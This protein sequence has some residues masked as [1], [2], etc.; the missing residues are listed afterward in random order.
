M[1]SLFKHAFH[2]TNAS[3][4][5]ML[6]IFMLGV[7]S[8]SS[9]LSFLGWPL[10]LICI[11][12][13]VLFY[14]GML[15]SLVEVISSQELVLTF[16]N[17]KKNIGHF[18]KF[19]FFLSLLPLFVHL[20]LTEW[21]SRQ[22][23]P[24]P[25]TFFILNFLVLYLFAGIVIRQKYLKPLRL[26]RR[27]IACT[28]KDFFA[29]AA[30]LF[31]S[32]FLVNI[33]LIFPQ[34]PSFYFNVASFLYQ[35]LEFF[36][37]VY[38]SSLMISNY[39]E[40]IKAHTAEKELY[41]VSPLGGAVM[42][43]IGSLF[44]RVYPPVFVVLKA[45][46]PKDYK[47]RSFNRI[48]WREHYYARDKLVAVTCFTS[49]S[50]EAYKIAKEFKRRGSKVIMGGPHVTY[51]PDEALQFCDSVVIG[52]RSFRILKIMRSKGNTPVCLWMISTARCTRN[53]S[54]PRRRSSRISW[55]RPGGANSAVISARSPP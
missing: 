55:K 19:Y 50:P 24:M 42:E 13:K 16:P 34:L 11:A 20:V 2:I 52:K 26:P 22:A 43:A 41:L 18:W 36:L 3:L 7:I 10:V 33:H 21:L 47:V 15:A 27:Q 48:T 38:M 35:Y 25:Q 46:S 53:C 40:I 9:S 30:L 44:M 54:I 12:L 5:Y 17:L 4:I 37:F 8:T 6:A 45:L 14:S 31:T 1:P 51:H 39:P 29:L 32:G 23:I 49:N 28:T